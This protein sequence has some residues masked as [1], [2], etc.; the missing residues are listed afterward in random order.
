MRACDWPKPAIFAQKTGLLCASAHFSAVPSPKVAK[1]CWS[2]VRACSIGFPTINPFWKVAMSSRLTSAIVL[3]L[4]IIA[5]PL[6]ASSALAAGQTP[7]AA[8]A[9]SLQVVI[10]A[11][12]RAAAAKPGFASL[13]A[14]AKLAA[15]QAAVADALAGTG[16]SGDGDRR[17]PGSGRA[18]EHH[19]RRRRHLGRLGRCA[20]NGSASRFEPDR[21]AA[22]GRDRPVGD[23]DGHGFDR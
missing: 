16:A 7:P 2:V 22:T 17:R 1:R 6:G 21:H 8:T 10:S 9:A 20:G 14:Q 12:A 11:A 15:I 3:G 18:V 5:S 13:S 4:A 23:G 19:Q